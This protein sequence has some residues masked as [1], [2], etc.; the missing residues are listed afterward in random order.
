MVHRT[1]S[2]STSPRFYAYSAV[3]RLTVLLIA[4]IV[5]AVPAMAATKPESLGQFGRWTAFVHKEGKQKVCYIAAPP[6]KSSGK[7]KKRDDVFIM[8]TH[9]PADK[10][11]N[12]VS[13]VAG[14]DYDEGVAVVADVD[15]TQ[16]V[17]VPNGDSAWTPNQKT[18]DALTN[19]IVKGKT[20]EITGVSKRGTRTVD[21]YD[22][23]GS[24]KA[25]KAIDKACGI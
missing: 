13:H 22:L 19:S 24:F 23:N 2:D 20:L 3:M 10:T 1:Q 5:I 6:V 17:M 15:G 18:D 16:Y 7:Y 4:L 11:R 12:V 21:T 14:Y 25:I 8:I 9:R